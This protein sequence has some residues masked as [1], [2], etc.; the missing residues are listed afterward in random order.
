LGRKSATRRADR[1]DP[2]AIQLRA[3]SSQ[4]DIGLLGMTTKLIHYEPTLDKRLRNTTLLLVHITKNGL[5]NGQPTA[6]V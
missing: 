4:R 2:F 3:G 6:G 1:P 5:A